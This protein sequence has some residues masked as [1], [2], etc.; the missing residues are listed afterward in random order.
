MFQP[1]LRVS[2]LQ[3]EAEVRL[4]YNECAL[5]KYWTTDEIAMPPILSFHPS[6][7]VGLEPMGMEQ[8]PKERQAMICKV[9]VFQSDDIVHHMF[10]MEFLDTTS[11]VWYVDKLSYT[12]N[13][14]QSWTSQKSALAHVMS[15][16]NY[17][18]TISV[19]S[20]S[21]VPGGIWAKADDLHGMLLPQ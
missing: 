20:C 2:D 21:D 10:S 14:L 16:L 3:G 5:A 12:Q 7:P 6:L 11:S 18:R 19:L 4:L 9:I 13:I 1:S 15:L 8:I 17:I